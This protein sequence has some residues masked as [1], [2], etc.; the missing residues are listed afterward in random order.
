MSKD[1]LLEVSKYFNI[2]EFEAK[3]IIETIFDTVKNNWKKFQ[4][5]FLLIEIKLKC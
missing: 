5:N 2:D 3:K 1:L 4:I